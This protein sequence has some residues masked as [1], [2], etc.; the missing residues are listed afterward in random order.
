MA[1]DNSPP[2]LKLIVTI[3]CITVVTLV[4]LDFVLKSYYVMMSE[5]AAREKLAPTT[6]VNDQK[7]AEKV[8]LTGAQVPIEAAIGQLS[9]GTRAAIIAPKESNDLT[10]MTGWSKAPRPA[11]EPLTDT[12]V[13]PPMVDG[14]VNAS[15]DG[16]PTATA[17]GLD[18]G[19]TGGDAGKAAPAPH[20]ATDGGK[21]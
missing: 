9:Q 11:P 8:A 3:A 17:A 5:E 1:I 2:K 20:H 6:E 18:G 13:A 7:A 21:H 12:A 16:G 14:G 15:A 10:A 19:V 4:C